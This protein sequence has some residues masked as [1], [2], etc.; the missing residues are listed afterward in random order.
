MRIKIVTLSLIVALASQLSSG[1]CYWRPFQG[2]A[3]GSGCYQQRQLLPL[4]P[5]LLPRPVLN[6]PI[7]NP[8][9]LAPGG[10]PA[11]DYNS[12][13]GPQLPAPSP[14]AYAQGFGGPQPGCSDCGGD[15]GMPPMPGPNVPPQDFGQEHNYP[16]NDYGYPN[17]FGQGPPNGY[18]GDPIGYPAGF[19]SNYQADGPTMEG[20]RR[21]IASTPMMDSYPP[22]TS[23]PAPSPQGT[24]QGSPLP[25]LPAPREMPQDKEPMN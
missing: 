17:D 3:C 9:I 7:L 21:V 25:L 12:Y 8:Q 20:G 18:P 11:I 6:R 14:N 1:C 10:A 16:P 13:A 2:G 24:F 4:I 22:P 19:G 15:R 5:P 23:Y